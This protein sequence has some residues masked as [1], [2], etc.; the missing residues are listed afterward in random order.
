[1]K[2]CLVVGKPFFLHYE[3]YRASSFLAG[4]TVAEIP[5]FV[6]G[7]RRSAFIVERTES[8]VVGSASY[9]MHV[10][11]HN[12]HDVGCV[13][14]FFYGCVIDHSKEKQNYVFLRF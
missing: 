5:L 3:I 7:K 9:Q 13:F 1:M 12:L 11:T 10:V 8:H 6:Y 4:E 14:D 2:Q